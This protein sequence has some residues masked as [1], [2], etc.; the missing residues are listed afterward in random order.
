MKR[1]REERGGRGAGKETFAA[2]VEVLVLGAPG[3]PPPRGH[4][5]RVLLL[6]VRVYVCG[7]GS[8]RGSSGGG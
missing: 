1:K 2:H 4:P 6:V 5:A 8:G 3:L 7:E